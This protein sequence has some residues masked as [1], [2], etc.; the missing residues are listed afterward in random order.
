VFARISAA[1][2]DPLTN[3]T[4]LAW[5]YGGFHGAEG[6]DTGEDWYLD[7]I[8]EELDSPCE[9]YFDVASQRL[10][11]FHNA[12]LGTPPPTGWAFE[13]PLLATLINASSSSSG[14]GG[15]RNNS[16]DVVN[17]TLSGLTFTGAA[18]SYLM[19][20]GVP[21][22]GDWGVSRLGALVVEGTVGFSVARCT[23]TRLDGNGVVLNGWNR[24]FSVEDSSFE[25]L[26]ESGVVSW[27]RVEGADARA[28]TQPW[29]S[30]VRRNLCSNIGLFE[31]QASCYFATLT[32]GATLE[33]NIFFNMPRAAV[34]FNDDMGGGSL[35]TRNLLFNTCR[36]SQDHGPFNSWGRT[37]YMINFPNGTPSGGLK[38]LVDEIGYNFLVA[39]GGANSGAADHDDGSAFYYD[40]HNF[41]VYGGHKSNFGHAKRSEANLMAFALVYTNQCMR[42]WPTLPP[43]SPGGVF[44]EAYVG[45]TCI[46]AEAGD[47]YLDLGADCVPGAA[48][49]AQ[50][51]LANNTILAPPGP[52]TASVKCGKNKISF[53][54]WV[55]S[56]SETGTTLGDL[57]DTKTII[58]WARTLL[59]ISL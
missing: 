35:L 26:G 7:H 40:H 47:V 39:G 30:V 29:G 4:A 5:T 6:S 18:A 45:N 17:V 13:V 22:G 36:E 11:Y 57:P 58:G 32:G 19:P 42:Q 55:A 14:G 24:F 2:T 52:D 50:I 10:Y 12:S 28:L 49:A 3:H 59:N 56:G 51:V 33:E 15:R 44:A 46:L 48:L 16:D 38:P 43:A 8:A 54:E 25:Y 23:F 21:A 31:K 34:N 27:G 1:V 37:P 41:M 53:S 9:F 20:H